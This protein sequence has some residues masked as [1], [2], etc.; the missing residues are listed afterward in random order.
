V[1]RSRRN[2]EKPMQLVGQPSDIDVASELHMCES[3]G[4]NS[5]FYM[6]SQRMNVFEGPYWLR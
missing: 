1:R 5:H 6:A 3:M 2:A 4:Q